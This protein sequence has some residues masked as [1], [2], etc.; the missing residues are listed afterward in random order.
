MTDD[1]YKMYCDARN[2]IITYDNELKDEVRLSLFDILQ[3]YYVTIDVLEASNPEFRDKFDT[4][5]E[6]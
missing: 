4:F 2:F 1:L 6:L 3:S 5:I